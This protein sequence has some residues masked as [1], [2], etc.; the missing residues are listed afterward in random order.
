MWIMLTP[1]ISCASFAVCAR[2]PRACVYLGLL[3]GQEHF[4]VPDLGGS[5]LSDLDGVGDA[6]D[7]DRERE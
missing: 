4:A 3:L 7:D 1:F 2:A 5:L 6:K